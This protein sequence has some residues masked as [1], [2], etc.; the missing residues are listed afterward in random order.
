MSKRRLNHYKAIL[1]KERKKVIEQLYSDKNKLD[2]LNKNEVGDVVDTA[3]SMY[4]KD[5]AIEMSE[6]EKRLLQTID[7]ALLRIENQKYGICTRCGSSID[8]KRLEV[9]P[10][11]TQC[12]DPKK[13]AKIKK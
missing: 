8:A 10:W 9:L 13:C 1:L 4:E 6:N 11:T 12:V 2:E 5:M 3:F 7:A